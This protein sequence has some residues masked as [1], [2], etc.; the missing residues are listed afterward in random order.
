MPNEVIHDVD[1]TYDLHVRWLHDGYVQIGVETRDGQPLLEAMGLSAL[2]ASGGTA[3]Q[4]MPDLTDTHY[5]G[6]YA[7]FNRQQL[8]AIVRAVRRSRNAVYEADE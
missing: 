6:V 5:K 3:S 4:D 2:M 7:T 1:N 8:N